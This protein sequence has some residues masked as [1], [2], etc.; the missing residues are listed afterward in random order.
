MST[1]IKVDRAI[2]L[3]K[4]C[5]AAAIDDCELDCWA[6]NGLSFSMTGKKKA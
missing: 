1:R 4:E 6:G 3:G 2:L 5:Y